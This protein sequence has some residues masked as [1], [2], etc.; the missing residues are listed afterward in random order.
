M[1]EYNIRFGDRDRQPVEVHL[2][3]KGL[4]LDTVT[5]DKEAE[6]AYSITHG[7]APILLAMGIDLGVI[8]SERN[9]VACIPPFLLD[10]RGAALITVALKT[11]FGRAGLG[12]ALAAA[13]DQVA[14]AA[15]VVKPTGG[16]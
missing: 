8:H 4:S 10:V 2:D 15:V 12:P 3:F 11:E 7:K 16:E 1:K 5:L 9:A 6:E 13:I 14:A